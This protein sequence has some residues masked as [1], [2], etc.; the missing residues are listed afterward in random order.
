MVTPD[1]SGVDLSSKVSVAVAR[2]T[3]D[4]A[5]AQGSAM[6]ALI[7]SAAGAATSVP[8]GAVSPAV[9]TAQPGRLDVL[10]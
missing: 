10:A 2:K 7:Q 9:G 3:L 1:L 8:S 4:A 5:K 6:V